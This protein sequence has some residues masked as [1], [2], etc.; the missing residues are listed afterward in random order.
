MGYIDVKFTGWGRYT[1]D[2]DEVDINTLTS[3]KSIKDIIDKCE[4]EELFETCED[5]TV[6]DN[7]GMSTV[8]VFNKN[9]ELVWKNGD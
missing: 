2:D 3:E 4:W 1:F 6:S 9:D 5:M 7:G 8:E